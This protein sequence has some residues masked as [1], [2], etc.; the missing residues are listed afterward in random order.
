MRPKRPASLVVMGILNIVFGS[1]GLLCGV[2]AVGA[3]MFISSLAS[4]SGNGF[5][6]AAEIKELLAFMDKNLPGYMMVEIGRGV[7]LLLLSVLLVVAGIGLLATQSWARWLSVAYALLSLP[8]HVGWAVF[9]LG[10]VLPLTQRWQAEF[11]RKHNAF[12]PPQENMMTSSAGII[13]A[14]IFWVVYAL[15]LL[16]FMFLPGLSA[17]FNQS[18]DSRRGRD[19][20]DTDDYEDEEDGDDYDPYDRRRDRY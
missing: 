13:A 11:M 4:G 10:F 18:R 16:I 12:A 1:L 19:E 2:C 7:A 3:N 20:G 17:A 6:G 8:L 15:I 9:E 14:T 5:P